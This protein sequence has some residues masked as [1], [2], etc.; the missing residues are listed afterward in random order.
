MTN[1][2]F[3]HTAKPFEGLQCEPCQFGLERFGSLSIEHFPAE[4]GDD[5]R[6]FTPPIA[7]ALGIQLA[8]VLWDTGDE[9]QT[10]PAVDE[11]VGGVVLV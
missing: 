5:A 10:A 2:S 7:T 6:H 9:V 11:V 1:G 4:Q 8:A 3:G